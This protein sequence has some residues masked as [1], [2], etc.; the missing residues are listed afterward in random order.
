M[1]LALSSKSGLPL[2]NKN[3]VVVNYPNSKV[4]AIVLLLKSLFESAAES[5]PEAGRTRTSAPA[6][7]A[8]GDAVF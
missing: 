7:A 2:R 6:S 4:P 3:S 5:F 8:N 1:T